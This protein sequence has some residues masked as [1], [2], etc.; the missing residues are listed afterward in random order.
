MTSSL[1]L[2][3]LDFG[4]LQVVLECFGEIFF[5]CVM[6]VSRLLAYD[7]AGHEIRHSPRLAGHRSSMAKR[8]QTLARKQVVTPGWSKLIQNLRH[9]GNL[10]HPGT[11]LDIGSSF[12]KIMQAST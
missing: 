12:R 10:E 9:S 2:G 6:G 8:K 5:R 11:I 4:L 1:S 3:I 7:A